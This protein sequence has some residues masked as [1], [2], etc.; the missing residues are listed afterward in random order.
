MKILP[1]LA[2][3]VLL[4][5]MLTPAHASPHFDSC[6]QR[7]G[8][9][10]TLI[11]PSSAINLNGAEMQVEDELAV[12]TPDGVCAGWAVWDGSSVALAVWE[13]DPM[14]QAVDGFVTGETMSYAV[15]DESAGVEYGHDS[16]VEVTYHA[17]FEDE[18]RFTPDAVYLVSSLVARTPLVMGSGT[19]LAFALS[20]NYPNPFTDRTTISY[21]LPEESL[22]RLEVYNLLGRRVGVLV[23]E[24]QPA[25]RHDVVFAADSG[26]ASGV[27]VYRL[28]AG[29]HTSHRKMVLV[30]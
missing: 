26:T 29:S 2:A 1:P 19:P 30:D 16:P 21:E 12:F 15:W 3:L 23:H 28:Q 20:G 24:T 9:S 8:S 11:V 27:Y 14:T 7:T 13:D 22:V 6:N 4:A 10:A 17:D 5:S 18:D 25:G